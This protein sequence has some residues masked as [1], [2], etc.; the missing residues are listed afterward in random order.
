LGRGLILI[1][2]IARHAHVWRTLRF[3]GKVRRVPRPFSF[4]PTWADSEAIVRS[5]LCLRTLRP[6]LPHVAVSRQGQPVP[7]PFSF[8]PTWADSGAVVRS[9]QVCARRRR[10]WPTSRF[11][12][13]VRVP[14]PFTFAPALADSGA[15]VETKKSPGIFPRLS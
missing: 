13:Q 7:R 3:P 2:D 9:P 8:A 12:I 15:L 4:T 6:R 1:A 11:P 5:P 10:V 14:R